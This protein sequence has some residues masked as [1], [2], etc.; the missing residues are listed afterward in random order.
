VVRETR[1]IFGECSAFYGCRTSSCVDAHDGLSVGFI[2]RVTIS[3]PS[4]R[5]VTGVAFPLGEA[6]GESNAILVLA[7]RV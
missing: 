4:K 1:W 2:G 3:Q 6:I 5:P 7:S